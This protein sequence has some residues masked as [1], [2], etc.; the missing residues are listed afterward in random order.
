MLQRFL[1]DRSGQQA[2]EYALI[3]V[4]CVIGIIAALGAIGTNLQ[5]I[6]GQA[7]AAFEG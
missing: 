2:I 6:F 3:A 7:A 4:L 1:N 5:D